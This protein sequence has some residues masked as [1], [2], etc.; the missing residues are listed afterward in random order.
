MEERKKE[1][2]LYKIAKLVVNRRNLILLFTV[3]GIV[4][5]MF[6]SGWVKVENDLVAFLPDD[7]KSSI[8]LN[9]MDDEF[10]TYGTAN[11]MISNITL[12]EANKVHEEIKNI[13]GVQSVDFDETSEHYKNASAYY[14]VTFDFDEDDNR[15]VDTLEIIENNFKNYDVYISTDL[16]NSIAEI[17][18]QEVAVIMVI[19][20][21]IVLLVLLLTS[22][23]F[24]E[25]PVLILTFLTA[26]ILNVGTNFLLGEISFVSNSVTSILQLAL[27]LDYAVILLNRFKEEYEKLP[28]KEAVIEALSKAIPEIGSSCLTTIG[29]MVAMMFMQFKLGQDMAICL[30]KAI[31]FAI[32]SVFLVMPGLLMIFG[33]WM[34]KTEH[35]NLVPK[36]NFVGKFAHKTRFVVPVLFIV[37]LIPCIFLSSSCPYAYGYGNLETAKLND[38]TIAENMI[39]DNFNNP[40]MVALVVPSDDYEIEKKLINEL[41]SYDEVDYTMGLSNIEAM[42][43]Y[44][45]ADK[46]NPREF[47]E[48]AD[49][50]YEVAQLIY[51]AYAANEEKYS[52]IISDISTYKVPLIDMFLF[53]CDQV[54]SGVVSLEEEQVSMLK[55]AKEQM[56]VAKVQLQGENYNRLLIY[57]NLPESGEP[58]YEFIDK[59]YEITSKY[60]N[61][62]QIY[63]VGNS[64]TEQ[65]FK[66]SFEIDNDVVSIVSILIVLVVLLFTFKS[67]GMPLVL[68]LV[69]QGSIW[70]NFSIPYIIDSP[71][72]FMS[73]LVVSSI[74]MGANIDYAIVMASRYN[75]IKDKMSKKEAIIETINFAFPT[76][77]TSGTILAVAG[78]LIGSMSSEAAICG[79]GANLGRGTIISIILVMFVLPQ[80]LLLF[81]KIVDKSSF[82]LP[83]VA[84]E[85]RSSIGKV[86]VNGKVYG[87]VKG[88]IYGDINAVIDGDVN[89]NIIAGNIIEDKEEE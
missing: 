48:L 1:G 2:F 34:K 44:M 43:G 36:I 58:T 21:I 54:D 73:Y 24:A 13:D 3:I 46:L 53:V 76:I 81:E 69:I 30:I 20:A 18:D 17:I 39:D 11:V 37:I 65:D 62:D 10:T 50:D 86:K 49:L 4:F 82:S 9:I 70:I 41:E 59:I 32:L 38:I 33:K 71:I 77:I 45:L 40:N 80:L 64:T 72:F 28:L 6:S 68:L 60:Y 26:M 22:K 7:S 31:I 27:S 12:E 79:I 5:S 56:N 42:D 83:K 57:L 19:V 87:D 23:T 66:I 16:G 89:L 47:S 15:C 74:Q 67:V 75:E 88:K 35:K 61:S 14:I 25:V 52:E 85:N 84:L 8:G 63:V 55:E 29:G 51:I 78:L